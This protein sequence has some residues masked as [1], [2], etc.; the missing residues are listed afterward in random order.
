MGGWAASRKLFVQSPSQLD[1]EVARPL[2]KLKEDVLPGSSLLEHMSNIME[3][4]G[5]DA[6]YEF[7]LDC[8]PAM[9]PSLP[10][11]VRSMFGRHQ[12]CDVA[13]ERWV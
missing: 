6:A 3:L 2:K 1:D 5:Y 10:D 12:V 13:L 7:A 9:V 8:A 11:C 4:S